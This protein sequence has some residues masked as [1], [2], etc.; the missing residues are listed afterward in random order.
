MGLPRPR[1]LLRRPR[2]EPLQMLHLG[3]LQHS[4]NRCL[5]YRHLSPSHAHIAI[6]DNGRSHHPLPTGSHNSHTGRSNSNKNRWPTSGNQK[7]AS[8]FLHPAPTISR[9]ISKGVNVTYPGAI[10]K[11]ALNTY[12]GTISKGDPSSTTLNNNSDTSKG[13]RRTNSMNCASSHCIAQ[14]HQTTFW[15]QTNCPQNYITAQCTVSHFAQNC[16]VQPPA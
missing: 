15:W 9:T 12:P 2:N 10:S 8:Q 5:G 3:P 14:T 7:P 11:G 16:H 1:R 13:A 4:S 6:I